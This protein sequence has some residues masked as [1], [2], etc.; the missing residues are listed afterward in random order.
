MSLK[1]KYELVRKQLN[2]TEVH[3]YQSNDEDEQYI[4]EDVGE[5][6]LSIKKKQSFDIASD[7]HYQFKRQNPNFFN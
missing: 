4:Y 7:Q 1:S 3:Q 5:Q 2:Q 6:Y